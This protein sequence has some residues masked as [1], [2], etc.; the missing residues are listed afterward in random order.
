MADYYLDSSA[1]VKRY[2]HEQGSDWVSTLFDA[3]PPHEIFIAVVTS[4]EVVAAISRRTLG[5]TIIAAD[6]TAA[7]KH[8]RADLLSDY[9]VVESNA[10]LIN[11]AMNLAETYKLRGYDAIQL[12]SAC[13]VNLLCIGSGLPP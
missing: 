5:G 8:F 9:Q 2:V 13:E 4:V 6:A 7:C 11:R 12:A 3:D 10:S 1:L